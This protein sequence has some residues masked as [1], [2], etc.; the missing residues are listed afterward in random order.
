MTETYWLF[1]TKSGAVSSDVPSSVAP[2]SV[3]SATS[4]NFGFFKGGS[5]S[6]RCSSFAE[7]L[8]LDKGVWRGHERGGGREVVEDVRIGVG[9]RGKL[10]SP[11]GNGDS[12]PLT[13]L[14]IVQSSSEV[15]SGALRALS[16]A[17]HL[18]KE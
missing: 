8:G 13:A 12:M 14:V 16:K 15:L 5:K 1:V 6:P 2:P 11:A 10:R 17:L 4:S 9:R 7:T 3:D 18:G